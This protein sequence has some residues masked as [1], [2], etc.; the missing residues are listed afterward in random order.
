[1]T[2]PYGVIP[3][4]GD[5]VT[6]E[7]RLRSYRPSQLRLADPAG[8]GDV[9]M[10]IQARGDATCKQIAPQRRLVSWSALVATAAA[11]EAE[12]A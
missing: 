4:G 3:P 2:T 10:Q 9:A 6:I 8:T 1:M 11:G 5:N 12:Q 7:F